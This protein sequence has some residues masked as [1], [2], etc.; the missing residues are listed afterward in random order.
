[1]ST[2]ST[3]SIVTNSLIVNGV[4][5]GIPVYKTI[6]CHFDGYP[7]DNRGVGN[8]LLRHYTDKEKV[9]NL[10]AHGDMSSIGEKIDPDG[11]N[12]HSFKE[13]QENV[14]TF[15]HRDRGD[16]WKLCKPRET[17]DVTE[18][19]KNTDQEYNYLFKD[20][21]WFIKPGWG[22]QNKGWIELE[23]EDRDYLN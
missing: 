8:M 7:Y 11:I 19:E 17:E 20:G 21:K 12:P 23:F 10:I 3:I 18:F 6:Y 5:E 2:R 16:D 4:E 15:Y 1:M 22:D 9:E 13:R 14:C